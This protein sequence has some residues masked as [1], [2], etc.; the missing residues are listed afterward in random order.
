MVFCPG[1]IG[2][3]MYSINEGFRFG[4]EAKA[5]MLGSPKIL[6]AVYHF[7]PVAQAGSLIEAG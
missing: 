5:E 4:I 6:P 3:E 2:E 1:G 7:L